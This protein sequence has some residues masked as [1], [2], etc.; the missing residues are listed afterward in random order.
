MTTVDV[1]INR[2]EICPRLGYKARAPSVSIFSLIDSQ[3]ATARNL[4]KPIYTYELKTINDVRGHEVFVEGSLVFISKTVSYVLYDCKRV[5]VFLVT[6]G[7][8]LD[9]EMSKL[10]VKG[11]TLEAT[12]LDAIG[13]EAVIQSCRRL[14][15]VIRGIAQSDGCRA[16][17]RYSPGY[18]DWDVSQQKVLFQAMDSDSV[19]VR[20]TASCLMIPSKSISGVIGIGQFD[21]AKPPPCLAVCS[22]RASCSH[23]RESWDPEKRLWL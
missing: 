12:I 15:D 7:N 10:M 4:I 8:G 5:A 6:I 21:T 20:L 23:K 16:T 9:E 3:I 17:I 1:D 18:C 19:G 2:E 13:T 14:Q 11:Q 22:K